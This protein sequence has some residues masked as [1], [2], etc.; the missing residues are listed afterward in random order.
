MTVR[1]A[2]IPAGGLGTRFLPATK[3]QPK[4][5]VPVVDKPGIQYIVEEA[6]R[7]GLDDILIITSRGKSIIEDHFDR[8][9]ELEMELGRGHKLEL[10]DESRRISDLADIHYIRQKQPAG[11]G[12][13]VSLARRH[14]GDEPFVVMVG[15]EI[16]PEP[17]NDEAPLIGKMIEAFD[18]HAGSVV[19]VQ[20]VAADDVS[21]YGIIDYE[22]L[23]GPFVRVRGMVEKP[24]PAEAPSNLASRG[25][26]LFTPG[27]FDAIDRTSPGVG[28]EIQ[29][30]DAIRILIDREPVFAYVHAG[31]IFDFGKKLDYL[32]AEVQLAMR[33]D[34]LAKDRKSVV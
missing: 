15:D 21:A 28:N 31:P 7:A 3:A 11:F 29:L 22:P 23:E 25:R 14:V 24:P 16:V 17:V 8:A 33:R 6:V 26:Y 34:D 10:L 30:T 13:A 4:E 20:E 2:V 18:K 12:H 19:T 9:P 5:M 1:K 27:I 32:R